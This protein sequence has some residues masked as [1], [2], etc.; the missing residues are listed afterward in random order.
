MRFVFMGTPE[1]SI[2]LMEKLNEIGD[3]KLVVTQIDKKRGRGK[4]LS[5]S[6]VKKRAEEL[7]LEV[8]QPENIND[9][10]SIEKL[11]EM[12]ADLFVIAAYGQILKEE[13]LNL[14]KYYSVNAHASL[15]PHLRGASPINTAIINGDRESGITIMKMAKELDKGDM[16][17]KEKVEIGKK[18]AGELEEELAKVATNLMEKFV[19]DL[20]DGCLRF[21]KQD[22]DKAS[23]AGKL[24][25]EDFIIDFSKSSE[26]I[27]SLIRGLAPDLGARTKYKGELL[28]IFA[29]EEAD[30]K[31]AGRAGQILDSDKK[32]I[33]KTGN[34]AISVT[35]LQIA[36]K[37]TMDIKSFLL[38]NSLEKNIILGE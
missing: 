22:D 17:L 13:V 21:E 38:G 28:K 32:L 16:A 23:Y 4:K 2:P 1:F 27:L 34:G 24:S 10:A 35:S 8:F 31:T 6:P 30:V 29:G 18:N 11:R 19:N 9:E 3:L 14:P 26:E 25:K 33:I 20:E 36:G 5:P 37:K 12:N 7:G 15:L